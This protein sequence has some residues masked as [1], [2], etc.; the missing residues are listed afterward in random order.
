MTEADRASVSG[1]LETVLATCAVGR[2]RVVLIEGAA[3]CG[4]SHLLDAVAE[5][6]AAAGALVLTAVATAAERRVPLGVL[7]QLVGSAPVFALPRTDG[8]AAE[9]PPE[10]AMRAFCAELCDLALDGPVVLCLDD[11]QHAD[12][13]SLHHLR[14]LVRHAR[15]APVLLVA[16][17]SSYAESQQDLFA[18]ELTRQPHFRRIRLGLLSPDETTRTAAT[19]TPATRTAAARTAAELHRVTGGNPLLLRALLEEDGAAASPPPAP[20]P[21]GPFAEAA[22]ACLHRSGPAAAVT[23]RAVAILAEEAAEPLLARMLHPGTAAPGLAALRACGLLDGL[24]FRHPAVPAAV[25]ADA[26][27]RIRADLHRRA[28]RVLREAGAPAAVVADHLLAPLADGVRAPARPGDFALLADTAEHLLTDHRG[29]RRADQAERLLELAHGICPEEAARSALTLR[30]AQLATRRDPD[31]AEH[32]LTALV[33]GHRTPRPGTSLVRELSGMLLAQGRVPDS[34][35]LARGTGA[36]PA[37][38]DAVLDTR[39]AAVETLVRSTPLTDAT[40]APLVLAVRTLLH[41]ERPE[42]AVPAS[43]RLLE[44]AEASRAPGRRAVFGTLHAEALLGVGDVRGAREHALAALEALPAGGDGTFR[45]APA[46]VLVQAYGALGRYDEAARHVQYPV[47]RRVL[48]SLHGLRYLRAR[49]LHHLALGQPHTALADFRRIGRLLQLWRADRPACLPWRT[50]A[51]QAL[52]RLDKVRQARALAEEQLALPDA[53]R[54]WVRGQTLR[55]LAATGDPG[56]R[57]ALL[58]QAVEQLRR[59]GARLETARALADLGHAL[60]ADG[61]TSQAT[62]TL[63]AAWNLAQQ[64]GATALRDDLLPASDPD[65]LPLSPSERRVAAL[66]AQGLTNRHI[67]ARLHLTVSTVEQHLTRAYR[68][69]GVP[70]RT[71]LPAGLADIPGTLV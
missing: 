21:D 32:R 71:G 28:A 51:A 50:D 7:R 37:S 59:S 52:L 25:L 67:A 62:A 29:S 22:T 63:R 61:C 35:A 38:W 18:P 42:R 11:V 3:G 2:S 17:I 41:C 30:L 20:A 44:E 60:H 57:T 56:E 10:E 70:G 43:R 58:R 26:S 24:L 1:A 68:K 27:P 12:T 54:P 53:R 6:S 19:R 8:E 45:Y 66:A 5:R 39:P 47:T 49:G 48:T 16:T 14:H 15:P 13:Q 46:A 69:L 55:T 31:A 34:A 36:D 40:L 4:K 64:M 65:P 33:T 9:V 23:A